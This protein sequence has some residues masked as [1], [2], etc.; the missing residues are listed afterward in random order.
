MLFEIGNILTKY[1]FLDKRCSP[2]NCCLY[3]L[4]LSLILDFPLKRYC[5]FPGILWVLNKGQILVC[6]KAFCISGQQICLR[7]LR[8]FLPALKPFTALLQF[9]Y[10]VISHWSDRFH[11]LKY[12]HKCSC[13]C[14]KSSSGIQ[15]CDVSL[16]YG[17]E[18][19]ECLAKICVID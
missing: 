9:P 10:S 6:L 4:E 19:L 3:M 15:I 18:V 1:L 8:I 7:R 5:K 13:G 16:L 17:Q 12:I 14:Q 2:P 11:I